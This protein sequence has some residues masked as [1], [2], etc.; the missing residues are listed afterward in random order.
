M[1]IPLLIATLGCLL[2]ASTGCAHRQPK[3][4]FRIIGEG[5]RNP[6]FIS[7]PERAGERIRRDGPR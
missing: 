5:E 4:S 6:M 2:L 3:S 1:N 7:S